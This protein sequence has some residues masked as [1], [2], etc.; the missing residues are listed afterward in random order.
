M[1]KYEGQIPLQRPSR[2]WEDNIEMGYLEI[3]WWGGVD[4]LYPA[5]DG[6]R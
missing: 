4:M 1:G 2:I 5:Q 6:D 3:V